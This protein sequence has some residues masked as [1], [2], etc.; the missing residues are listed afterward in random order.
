M[1]SKPQQ[2][3][4]VLHNN[5]WAIDSDGVTAGVYTQRHPWKGRLDF[6]DASGNLKPNV[7]T[8]SYI[9]TARSLCS[10][11]HPLDRWLHRN[12]AARGILMFFIITHAAVKNWA[13][14]FTGRKLPGTKIPTRRFSYLKVAGNYMP[15]MIE[16][17]L[18][19]ARTTARIA[20]AGLKSAFPDIYWESMAWGALE[21]TAT[22]RLP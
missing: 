12:M 5:A 9:A 10:G 18:Y 14:P 2:E 8:G 20:I 6:L 19:L 15:R 16:S 1:Y 22:F 17:A 13:K 3:D 11:P 4:G 7:D 21:I